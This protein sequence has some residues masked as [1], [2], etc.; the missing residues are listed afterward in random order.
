M[1]DK[2]DSR[3]ALP[4]A[5]STL[6]L[7]LLSGC[8]VGPDFSP[9]DS[10]LPDTWSETALRGP[11]IADTVN[12]DWWNGFNDPV[13][14]QLI[15]RV[16]EANLDLKIAV[17]RLNQ[18]KAIFQHVSSGKLPSVEGGLEYNRARSSEKGLADISGLDGKKNFNIWNTGIDSTWEL[19]LWGRVK[20]AMEA[21]D[22]KVTIA[23][24]DRRSIYLSLMAETAS[25]YIK[26]RG[27]QEL[28]DVTQQN[29]TTA[30]KTLDLTCIKFE[31]G[32][33]TDLEVSQASAVKASIRARV[34]SL[35][36]REQEA[37][38]ALG[39]LVAEPPDALQNLLK[40]RGTV[41]TIDES[42]G[43]GV[44][45]ELAQRRPD[46]WKAEAEL[47]AAT[48]NIGVA[49]ANFYPSITLSGS[50]GFQA[51]QLSD[52]GSWNTRQFS[53]GP[54]LSVPVFEGGRLKAMLEFSNAQQRQAALAYQKVVLTAWHEANNA[55]SGLANE[56]IRQNDLRE[57]VAQSQKA[58]DS[59]KL[60]YKQG[61]VDYLNVLS[62]QDM[63]LNNQS[64]LTNSKIA[65]S[66]SEVQLY[67]A[68]GGGW[69]APLSRVA[70]NK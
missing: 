49:N 63:L 62:V 22:A 45:S 13:L 43:I 46:I 32:V 66:L 50:I 9:P 19:D 2:F 67:K 16:N 52:L 31:Q 38:S 44:P 64:A 58:F 47:H 70:S 40:P 48:A 5:A 20:H 12:A 6:S 30:E 24:A 61:T 60:Q 65:A 15:K 14:S 26:L 8:M 36:Q 54:A 4:C 1:K 18:S 59:A 11:V 57:S 56:R 68:L 21:A 29:L 51:N 25:I 34:P 7:L 33:A 3:F 55:I 28:L 42:I 23:E 27:I 39:L 41:P 53:F 35:K 37:I 17:E 10:R 69:G